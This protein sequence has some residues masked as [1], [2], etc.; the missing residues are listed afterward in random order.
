MTHTKRIV[1]TLV[2]IGVLGGGLVWAQTVAKTADW[3]VAA[4]KATHEQYYRLIRYYNPSDDQKAK[5]KEVLVAQY[6][7]LKDHDRARAPKIK[8]I[9]DQVAAINV[10]IAALQKEASKIAKGKEIYTASRAELLLDHE[11]EINNI[12]SLDQ[13]IARLASYIRG[14]AVNSY[15]W[16]ALSEE[17]RAAIQARCETAA[18]EILQT[19]NIDNTTAARAAGRAIAVEFAKLF[20]PEL[21]ITGES[22]YLYSS[23]MRRFKAIKMTE[24]QQLAMRDICDK[25]AK[26][27]SEIYAK[28][29]QTYKDLDMIRRARSKLSSSSYYYK[30][31]DDVVNNVLTDEQLKTLRLKRK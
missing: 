17:N 8:E 2:A 10:K 18:G 12:F 24:A 6:K 28:Y 16:A 23:T 29:S 26:H 5:I 20:T 11:A 22:D 27:K 1:F 21:R 13:K 14:S 31:R 25:A 15:T 9:D 3:K 30:I 7:D 19:G 4:E